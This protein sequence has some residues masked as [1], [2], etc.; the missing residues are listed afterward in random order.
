MITP[1]IATRVTPKTIQIIG[2]GSPNLDVDSLGTGVRTAK[3]EGILG[4]MES[5]LVL[6]VSAQI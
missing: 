3:A 5:K 1:A 4:V 6:E 2:I